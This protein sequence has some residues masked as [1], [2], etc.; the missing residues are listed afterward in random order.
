[1]IRL[2]AREG[3][4]VLCT[5]HAVGKSEDSVKQLQ[6]RGLKALKRV[7]ESERMVA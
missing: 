3:D 1:M 4:L 2:V 5:K 6:S 7:L